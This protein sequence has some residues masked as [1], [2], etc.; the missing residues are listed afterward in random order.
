M[1]KTPYELRFELLQMAQSILIEN[2][3]NERMR[4][5]NDWNMSCETSRSVSEI[6]HSAPSFPAFPKVP[7]ITEEDIIKTAKILNEF[8]SNTGE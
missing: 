6:A 2:L 1:S 3:M 7:K 8:V 5:E 4:I